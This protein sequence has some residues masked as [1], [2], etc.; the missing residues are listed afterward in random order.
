MD[1]ALEVA[2]ARHDE[3]IKA[4]EED[5]CEIQGTLRKIYMALMTL[6][7]GMA[8]SLGLQLLRR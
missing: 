3:R 5:L 4:L 1:D 8:V 7:G 6:L 2:V